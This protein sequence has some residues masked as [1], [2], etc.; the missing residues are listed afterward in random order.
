MLKDCQGTGVGIFSF[1]TGAGGLDIGL[2]KENLGDIVF[3]CEI[4]KDANLTLQANQRAC[5]NQSFDIFEVTVELLENI[6]HEYKSG[7][8]MLSIFVGGIPCPSFST[9]G[10]RKS[11]E[12]RRGTCLLKFL[13]LAVSF[14][15]DYIVLEN[16][17][18][19]LSSVDYRCRKNPKTLKSQMNS[20]IFEG[21]QQYPESIMDI[22][23]RKLHDYSI[24]Y[25]LYNSKYFGSA[26]SR[27]RMIM[28]A[29]LG[30]T[31]ISQ[32]V[33]THEEYPKHN[34]LRLVQSSL[35][36]ILTLRDVIGDLENVVDNCFEYPIQVREKYEQLH[37]GDTW[38]NLPTEQKNKLKATGI[39]RTGGVSGLYRRLSFDR[40]CPTLLCSPLQHTTGFCH[41]TKNRPLS[42]Q[43]Y[44]RIQGFDDS[45]VIC[46][47]LSSQYRQL[48]N[49]VPISMGRAIAVALK[50]HIYKENHKLQGNPKCSDFLGTPV[51]LGPTNIIPDEK[52]P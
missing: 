6:W 9:A 25:G 43:E 52:L 11:L 3:Q 37:S 46:G 36:P 20:S 14:K 7:K 5:K 34:Q 32:L 42:V 16:V 40:P 17:R 24:T 44:K 27:E 4:D 15:A 1:C 10:K 41:P 33:P 35:L 50:M 13:E 12:D 39:F 51:S 47:S 23:K 49:A 45:Y 30:D 21:Q 28:T 29:Y 19:I 31:C 8:N 38:R 2:E 26:Q 22:I 48:G 18:G